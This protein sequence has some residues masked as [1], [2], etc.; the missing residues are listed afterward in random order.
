MTI[1]TIVATIIYQTLRSVTKSDYLPKYILNEAR[2]VLSMSHKY[3]YNILPNPKK[4]KMIEAKIF[5]R[6]VGLWQTSTF[7]IVLNLF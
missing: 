4:S 7:C 5:E 1:M 3:F 6:R 2:N